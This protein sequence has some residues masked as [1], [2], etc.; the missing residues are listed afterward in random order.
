MLGLTQITQTVFINQTST[1]IIK[2]FEWFYVSEKWGLWTLLK[3]NY[4]SVLKQYP[5]HHNIISILKFATQTRQL[6]YEK[7]ALLNKNYNKTN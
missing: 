4:M 2:Y 6:V 7:G 3:G 5:W 1:R